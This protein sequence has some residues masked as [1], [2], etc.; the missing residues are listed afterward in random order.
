MTL[1]GLGKRGRE[2]I[3]YELPHRSRLKCN[4]GD[5]KSC[6][7][8][9]IQEGGWERRERKKTFLVRCGQRTSLVTSRSSDSIHQ[10]TLSLSTPLQF[11]F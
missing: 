8:S 3:E 1:T 10:S 2:K 11:L 6:K 5:D 7:I 4:Q 9:Y